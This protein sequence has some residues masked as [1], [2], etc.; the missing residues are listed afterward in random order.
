MKDRSAGVADF[1]ESILCPILKPG[2]LLYLLMLCMGPIDA[3]SAQFGGAANEEELVKQAY[4]DAFGLDVPF[5]AYA[6]SI[7]GGVVGY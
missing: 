2:I 7:Q 6:P 4:L 5:P 1:S 3:R